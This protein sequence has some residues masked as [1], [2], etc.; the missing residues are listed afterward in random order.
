[1][2]ERCVFCGHEGVA[3]RVKGTAHVGVCQRCSE[4]RMKYLTPLNPPAEK[5]AAAVK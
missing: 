3:Y 5:K 1:M 4:P 2:S